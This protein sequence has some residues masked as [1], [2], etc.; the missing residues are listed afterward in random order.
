MR[1]AF[2][3]EQAAFGAQLRAVLDDQCRPADVRA[4]WGSF[5]GWDDGRWAQLAELGVVGLTVPVEHGGLGLGPVHLVGLLQELGWAAAPEPVAETTALAVPLLTSLAGAGNHGAAT[6][7]EEIAAGT[8]VATVAAPAVANAPS[9]PETDP[10]GVADPGGAQGAGRVADPGG[11]QGTGRTATLGNQAN[12]ARG[13][14]RRGRR[15]ALGLAPACADLIVALTPRS[16]HLLPAGSAE[17]EEQQAMDGTRRPGRV[18]VP[19]GAEPAASGAVAAAMWAA[20]VDR[21]AVAHGALLLGLADRMLAMTVAYAGERHQF[22]RPVGS[23]QAIKHRLADVAVRLEHARPAVHRAAWSL[24]EGEPTVARDASMAKAM[25]ADVAL[26][27]ARAAL[28]VHGAI[29]YTWEHDLHLWMKRAWALAPA[30]GD[31]GW[32]RARLLASVTAAV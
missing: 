12:G 7:L 16:V 19:V 21:A 32:H 10:Q 18:D 23:F 14:A 30:W 22:G 8:M 11:A 25:A 15:R 5:R 13:G 17:V 4:A 27:A 1:F 3:A 29:G 6:A 24:H 2:T 20:T 31:A 9:G 28:Q 26:D